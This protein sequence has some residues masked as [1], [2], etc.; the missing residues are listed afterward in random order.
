MTD[1]TLVE[2]ARQRDYE[3]WHDYSD[4]QMEQDEIAAAGEHLPAPGYHHVHLKRRGD[5]FIDE[6]DPDPTKTVSLIQTLRTA[7][8]KD[9][10]VAK[11]SPDL[12]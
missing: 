5:D 7:H 2:Q 9:N 4:W 1:R 10:E 3:R 8:A 12:A 6:R 11:G